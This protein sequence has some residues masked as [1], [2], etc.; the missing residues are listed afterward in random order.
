[1]MLL[2]THLRF[3][4]YIIR[5]TD[6]LTEYNVFVQLKMSAWCDVFI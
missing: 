3:G 5:M 2:A 6:V 4:D 1:M